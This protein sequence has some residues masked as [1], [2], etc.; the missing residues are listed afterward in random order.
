MNE[1]SMTMKVRLE[2][3]FRPL[4]ARAASVM[5]EASSVVAEHD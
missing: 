3:R 2:K 5:I 4:Y 1:A